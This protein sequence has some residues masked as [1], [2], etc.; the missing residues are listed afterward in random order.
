MQFLRLLLFLALLPLSV[1]RLSAQN[2]PAAQP[3]TGGTRIEI[4]NA[5]RWDFDARIPGAQRLVGAVQFRHGGALMS[6]DS[7]Y[8]YENN[9][10]QA[11]GRVRILH[12]DTLTITGDRLD[13]DG[14]QRTATITG[15]VRLDDPSMSMTTDALSYDLASRTARYSTGAVITGKRDTNTLTSRAGSYFAGAHRFVFSKEV[16]LQQ[17]DRTIDADTLHYVTTTGMA[18]FHGPTRIAQGTG[19]LWTERGTY[20]TRTGQGRFTKAGRVVDQGQELQGDTLF[21]DGMT[22]KAIAYGNVAMLDTANDLEVRGGH[23]RHEVK[24]RAS[25]VTH[26]AELV[27]HM[28]S[29]A[30]H[31]HADTLFATTDSAGARLVTARRG[32]RFFRSDLQGVCD[33]MLYAGKDSI[34][35]LR[36]RPVIWSGA[37]QITGDTVRI[38]LRNGRAH[39]L[40]VRGNAFLIAR[41]D[42]V[43]FDQVAGTHMV[44]TFR[45][46]ELSRLEVVGNCRTA[47]FARE[48]QPDS[49]QKIIGVNRA[50]C[51]RLNVAIEGG[52]VKGIT[53]ITK[54]D[55]V[56]HP[57]DKAPPEA[58]VLKGFVWH[59]AL[60]PTDVEDIFRP[61]PVAVAVP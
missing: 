45:N 24:S 40:V 31:L 52:E 27:L 56:L 43:H 17:P 36:G 47:Y 59:E 38:E 30:L 12:A 46:N 9:T 35:H 23:G 39:R 37:D 54:P 28:D 55:A 16:H 6:C 22:G 57:L 41:A 1:V 13:Y 11:F 2:D 18:E 8:L 48:E 21:Y 15:N 61:V 60:R 5:D 34:I 42:S 51:S 20:D 4:V 32:V 19:T 33:T 26:R 49:T 3:R 53:F 10:V 58:L 50:D 7:A 25:F 29:D 44:G 14:N